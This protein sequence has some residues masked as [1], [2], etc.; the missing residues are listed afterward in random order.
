M[1]SE[2][3]G[4]GGA[5]CSVSRVFLASCIPAYNYEEYS[6]ILTQT[7]DD[8]YPGAGASQGLP[9]VTDTG[10]GGVTLRKLPVYF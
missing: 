5:G 7:I 10:F 1:C 2:S 9:G 4:S 8:K 6:S 3:D